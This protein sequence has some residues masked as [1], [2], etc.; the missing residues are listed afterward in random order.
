[1][2][3][4]LNT[5]QN[6]AYSLG[7]TERSSG[8]ELSICQA[9]QGRARQLEK[10]RGDQAT[11]SPEDQRI[12]GSCSYSHGRP[13]I[14]GSLELGRIKKVNFS[15]CK[16]LTLRVFRSVRWVISPPCKG[17]PLT[18]RTELGVVRTCNG[19]HRHR[20]R[21]NSIKLPA[22]PEFIRA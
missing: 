9:Q 12:C 4:L 18:P 17:S 1:M 15:T 11:I 22:A 16:A 21:A 5:F 6:P 13:R 20:P 3:D 7:I 10:H 19:M 14:T 8:S 2:S